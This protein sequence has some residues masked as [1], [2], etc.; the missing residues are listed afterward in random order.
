[1]WCIHC[2][3]SVPEQSLFCP[4]CGMVINITEENETIIECSEKKEDQPEL[5]C[6]R[7]QTHCSSGTVYCPQ[8]GTKLVPKSGK[9]E[10]VFL[11]LHDFFE[12]VK[13]YF[14]NP[15]ETMI[16]TTK[17][18][19]K[20]VTLMIAGL[21]AM[22]TV[23]ALYVA[24]SCGSSFFKDALRTAFGYSG[25]SFSVDV[26]FFICLLIGILLAAASVI[27]YA[28]A[29]Y[30]L[31]KYLG[32]LCQFSHVIVICVKSTVPITAILLLSIIMFPLSLRLGLF[33]V[34][35]SRIVWYIWGI[36]SVYAIAPVQKSG[37]F[38]KGYTVIILVALIVNG[39]VSFQMN[40]LAVQQIP[41]TYAGSQKTIHQM[42][43]SENIIGF[44]RFAETIIA[45]VVK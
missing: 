17:K 11:V 4:S 43:K 13:S 19:N 20:W 1:M 22:T 39:F 23:L 9:H 33:F 7:C 18:F 34:L 8:C 12:F 16:A 29:Y 15:V 2:G 24:L 35:L 38:L 32:Q 27:I 25:Y 31:S 26:P 40:W 42:M 44:E 3:A 37:K 21:Y 41:L 30:L 36:A 14:S 6:N 5:I 28:T 10:R 45:Q